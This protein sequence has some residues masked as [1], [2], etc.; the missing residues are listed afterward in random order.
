MATRHAPRDLLFLVDV[1]LGDHPFLDGVDWLLE[2]WRRIALEAARQAGR[3][4][5]MNVVDPT[6]LSEALEAARGA[7]GVALLLHPRATTTW[8]D[9]VEGLAADAGVALAI[10]PEGGFS[11]EEI[12]L[13]EAIGFRTVALGRFTMRTETA[14]AAALGALVAFD[15]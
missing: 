11:D 1:E 4:D 3:G 5:V 2:R 13:A 12:A 14:C 15:G 9:A 8:R 10:G 7:A 6:P